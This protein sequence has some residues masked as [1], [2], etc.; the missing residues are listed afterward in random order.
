MLRLYGIIDNL[1]VDTAPPR[2]WR[3]WLAHAFA[4]EKYDESSLNAEEKELLTQLARQIE[5][6]GV[7]PAA[8]MWFH[9]NRHMSWIGSQVLVAAA[10]L[11][12]MAHQFVAPMLRAL[13]LYVKPE[14]MPQL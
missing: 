6:R 8:I 10:P 14:D 5:R 3:A 2:G 12:D 13:G 4:V 9:S 1:L 11:D 7:G